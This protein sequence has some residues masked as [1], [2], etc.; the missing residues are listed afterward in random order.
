MTKHLL[1]VAL[2]L[3]V[4]GQAHAQT[5]GVRE[6]WATQ[7]Y[8][9]FFSR[10]LPCTGEFIDDVWTR[11]NL[12]QDEWQ[13]FGVV[14]GG[15]NYNMPLGRTISALEIMAFAGT[16]NPHCD[17]ESDLVLDWAYCFA[18]NAISELTPVCD[19][20]GKSATTYY[21][22]QLDYRTELHKPFFYDADVPRRVA[23]LFH[24]ARHADGWCIHSGACD[25]GQDACDRT[26][27][28]G[29]V[30]AGSSSGRGAYAWSVIYLQRYL[31]D[32]RPELFDQVIHERVRQ[33][34]NVILG[35][36]FESDPCFRVTG[37]RG[38]MS[39]GVDLNGHTIQSC[40][41]DPL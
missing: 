35:R 1:I 41:R 23:T 26:F 24:E 15:C 22:I 8:D 27:D 34:A 4:H 19:G 28:D 38:E 21:A 36:N 9:A 7:H 12:D 25:A 10:V 39:M 11:F 37:I 31:R 17:W 16:P 3:L 29:C 2:L 14:E 32:S 5:C 20:G 33:S 30:G 18:G 6:P 40:L 13:Q